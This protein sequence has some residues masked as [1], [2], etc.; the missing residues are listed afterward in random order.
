[1]IEVHAIAEPSWIRTLVES[2][3]LPAVTPHSFA[4]PLG[5]RY[6]PPDDPQNLKRRW[7]IAVYPAP[8]E[9]VG[10]TQYDGALVVSGFSLDVGE[11]TRHFE[12]IDTVGWH[13]PA[14]YTGDLDGPRI[15]VEG[16]FLS[17]RVSLHVHREP[18][19]SEPAA[20][21]YNPVSGACQIP[22]AA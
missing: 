20:Y 1:M 18:P 7:L 3:V 17:N 9:Y 5:Y 6:W 14:M 8:G 10:P 11:I 4:G 16:E 13:A 21:R 22:E 2:V 15:I 19:P 12:Q